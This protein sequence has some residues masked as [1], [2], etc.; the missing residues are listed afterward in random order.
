MTA[1]LNRGRAALVIA[2]PGHELCIY[3]W[4]ETVRPH[5][6]VLT[7]GAGRAGVPRL[8][9]TTK[10]L[11][12]VGATRGSI[13]GRFTDLSIYAAL[14]SRDFGLFERLAEELAVCFVREEIEYVVGDAMEGYNPVHDVCRLVINAAAEL[15]SRAS[16]RQ[17]INRDFLLVGPHD[18]HPE[19]LCDNALRLRLDDDLFGRK[20]ATAR[21]Y[22]ELQGEVNALLDQR[23]VEALRTFP[24]LSRYVNKVVT[25]V[26]GSEAYRVEC[27]RLVNSPFRNRRA[28]GNVPF[29]ERYG[30]MMVA[31]GAYRHVIRYREHFAPLAEAVWRFVDAKD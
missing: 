29:Y 4:L 28:A 18:A 8:A 12:G 26:M 11:S 19:G 9:S 21:A 15:A 1:T 24:E 30:E 6:S 25:S 17:I 2:H 3:G 5:V 27:L 22:P 10:I 31:A 14:L 7:D 20:L 13:Y 23:T 16:G